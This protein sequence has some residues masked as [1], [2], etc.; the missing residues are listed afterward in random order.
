MN[1]ISKITLDNTSGH[2]LILEF[3]D[4][5]V[6]YAEFS[7][8]YIYRPL[9]HVCSSCF[10][11]LIYYLIYLTYSIHFNSIITILISIYIFYYFV[12]LLLVL[13]LLLLL[14]IYLIL[15]YFYIYFYSL[16]LSFYLLSFFYLR[17]FLLSCAY[18]VLSSCLI[19]LLC[20]D[21]LSFLCSAY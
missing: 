5:V 7:M 11:L 18:I 12:Y 2:Y 8:V 6:A 16:V 13:F 4:C 21:L 10:P 15:L 3:R 20:L 9:N 19:H 17:H 1:K 14:Y